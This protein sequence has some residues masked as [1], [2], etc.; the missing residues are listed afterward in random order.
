MSKRLR[1][2]SVVGFLCCS[3]LTVS[4]TFAQG[5]ETTAT[6]ACSIEG[7]DNCQ[8]FDDSF[9][10]VPSDRQWGDTGMLA[11]DDFV[12]LEST[13]TSLCVWGFYIDN[14]PAVPDDQD[15]CGP[16]VNADHFRVRV[17]R[18][19]PGNGRMPGILV[20]ESTAMS[21]RE[22]LPTSVVEALLGNEMYAYQMT[23]NTPIAD[24]AP[25]QVYW[26]EVSNDPT[27]SGPPQCLWLWS[28]RQRTSSTYSVTVGDYGYEPGFESPFDNTFCTNFP[29]QPSVLGTQLG[30]CCTCGNGCS[31]KTLSD[32]DYI[33]GFWDVTRTTCAGAT[34]PSFSTNDNCVDGPTIITDGLYTF[35]NQCA[36]TD[37]YGPIDTEYGL[38]QI[39]GDLWYYF[40][41]PANCVL[42]IETCFTPWGFD[43][44][45]AVYHVPDN[46]TACPPCALLADPNGSQISSATLAGIGQDDSCSPAVGGGGRWSDIGQIARNALAG[47]CFLIRVGGFDGYRGTGIL[48]VDCGGVAPPRPAPDPTGIT[49]SR[50]VSFSVPSGAAPPETAL[51]VK[52]VA[53]HHVVPPY[54]G[55]VSTPFTLFEGLTQ[56]VGQPVQYICAACTYAPFYASK[57]QCEPYYHD[58]TTVGLLH[59]TGEAIVP[60]SVYEVQNLAASCMGS[61]ASCTAVS[62][63][64]SI[65]TT[66]WGDVVDAF[67]PP[68]TTS[69]PD[70]G[71]I[72]ALVNKFKGAPGAPIKARALLAGNARGNID[73]V[74]DLG[75]GHI[76][77]C[78]D[79][80]KGLAYPYK[81]GKCTNAQTTA[82]TTNTD[83]GANGPCILCP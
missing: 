42:T 76:S 19:D 30:A 38:S 65:V 20:S 32:C 83:C 67:N 60:T 73:I 77:A 69:Q 31:E 43:T 62:T 66:R 22:V 14:D 12:P 68:S 44:V 6:S 25:G 64:L 10:F 74:P 71:D 50:F 72:A 16:R 57:L 5:E 49:K 41:A 46:P 55:G 48:S 47:E 81:P 15:D 13:L 36:T 8:P 9:N 78:V 35:N 4:P 63:P 37:G 24:L 29:I 28:Q 59:V 39:E 27:I 75:F 82:C 40:T 45:L 61:E 52:L 1:I 70:F 34:C 53:L 18:N 11:A 2:A 33:S 80:F 23:L 21:Q 26:L 3:A 17:Y 56:Y 58:W 7:P 51:R 79:A 54:T